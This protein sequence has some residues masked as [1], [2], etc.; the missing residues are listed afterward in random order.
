VGPA[1]EKLAHSFGL[2][3]QTDDHPEA[4]HYYRSD[5]FSLARVGVPAFSVNEGVLFKGHDLAWGEEKESDYVAHRYHQPSDKYRPEM[6]FT[7]N[8]KMA[9]FGFALGWQVAGQAELAG[10]QPG[11]EFEKARKSSQQLKTGF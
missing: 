8:A 2:A 11:D 6:D 4:G 3:I 7:G 10:W 1:V 5:H 9:K